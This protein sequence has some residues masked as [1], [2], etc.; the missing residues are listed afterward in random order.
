[1]KVIG[2]I[3]GMSWE[4]TA[5]YY[6]LLNQGAKQRLGGR[7][8]AKVLLYSID[9]DELATFQHANRWDE[10]NAL[11]VDAAKRLERGGADCVLICANTMHTAAP[12]VE[13]AVKI[14]LLHLCD[15]TA[16]AILRTVK[17]EVGLLGTAFTMEMPFY[18]DRLTQ[19]FGLEVLVPNDV[20]RAETH[21]IIFDELVHG[22]VLPESK[23]K[24]REII[25]RLIADG[26]EAII[27]G[28]TELMMI[29]GP[30]D[31]AVPL[32]DTTTLHCEAALD[33]ALK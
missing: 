30:E 1:M 19:K 22:R 7:H 5:H 32:F 13:A 14:P 24:Y 20:D 4:S 11:V 25:G 3:G 31:S 17:K 33:F 26:S 15:V 6:E 10:A 2:L 27:L 18:K 12:E 29:I 23:Q 9:F 16:E 21:R 28:C 8:S